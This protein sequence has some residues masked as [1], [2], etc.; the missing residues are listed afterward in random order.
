M[1]PRNDSSNRVG[2]AILLKTA[3]P[4]FLEFVGNGKLYAVPPYQRDYSWEE[5]HWDD[6]WNDILAL[7]DDPASRHYMGAVVVQ[8]RTDREFLIID[9]QQRLATLSIL[10]LVVIDRLKKLADANVE[11]EEN[12]ARAQG[13]R[14]RYIG[15]KD[16]ASL[17][18][19]SKLT[20]NTT[21]DPFY[22]DYLVQLRSPSNPRGLPKSNR[23][24]WK[25]FQWFQRKVDEIEEIR[26]DGEQLALL[27]N[28]VIA[29]R[30]LFILITVDDELNAYT[31]FETLNARGLE[32]SATDL[33]KNYLFSRVRVLSDL[34][35]LQ[36]RWLSLIQ[37]VSQESF[38][39]FLRYHLLCQLPKVRSNRLFKMIRDAVTDSQQVFELMNELENRCEVYAA[40]HDATHEYWLDLPAA[41][42]LVR[43]RTL[44]RSQQTM[45]ILFAA[46]EKFSPADFVRVLKMA[47]VF[48][49]RFSTIS[50]LNT[51]E[52][53]PVYHRAAK[54]I[55]DGSATC[56]GDVFEL[57]R[58]VYVDDKVFRQNLETYEIRTSGA[59]KKLAKYILCRLESHLTHLD[60]DYETDSASIEHVLPENP[61]SEWVRDMPE[62]EWTKWSYRLGNLTL[63]EPRSIRN[64]GN[65]LM[66]TKLDA[67]SQSRY[68]LTRE[69]A[70]DS[71]SDWTATHIEQRQ[72]QLAARIVHLWR[73]DLEK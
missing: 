11:P 2:K 45:P 35:V 30:L 26:C 47:N 41:K 71:S 20:L 5:E 32:L 48:T 66:E 12:L 46:W 57:L 15:E 9:G 13:L 16:P 73:S 69:I 51:N 31:V 55:L 56:P 61:A 49:F 19:S 58:G 23:Q 6:L 67:Y 33:L 10:A 60:I 34:A 29:R 54:A 28:E 4:D 24:M 40:L 21:D 14:Q 37:T 39:E 18:E 68:A 7:R 17:I 63:L 8:A 52:L 65:G 27:L 3:T 22:Q 59:G 62:S 44:L 1:S 36:R 72:N 50:N 43:E 70:Q 42:S 25:C 38:P 64:I 53:E